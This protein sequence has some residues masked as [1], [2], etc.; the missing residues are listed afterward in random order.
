MGMQCALARIGAPIVFGNP[1]A[2]GQAWPGAKL[3]QGK[4]SCLAFCGQCWRGA[5]GGPSLGFGM[6]RRRALCWEQAG[7][8]SEAEQKETRGKIRRQSGWK[9]ILGKES[10][11]HGWVNPGQCGAEVQC[12]PLCDCSASAEPPEGSGMEGT[13]RA[14]CPLRLADLRITG[15]KPLEEGA[16]LSPPHLLI[17]LSAMLLWAPPSQPWILPLIKCLGFDHH[18]RPFPCFWMRSMWH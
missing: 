4:G 14:W 2:H 15:K 9:H 5:Q 11:E 13:A 7:R 12:H 3:W 17:L 16:V 1:S 18:H 10:T 8:G 6:R